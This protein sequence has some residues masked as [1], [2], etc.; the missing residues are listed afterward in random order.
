M[1]NFL[2][3]WMYVSYILIYRLAVDYLQGHESF[4]KIQDD[5]NLRSDTREEPRRKK[6]KKSL[7]N[8]SFYSVLKF[9]NIYIANELFAAS[10]AETRDQDTK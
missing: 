6:Q 10:K 1:L 2:L 3:S 7:V 8:Y 5:D 9:I 4:L